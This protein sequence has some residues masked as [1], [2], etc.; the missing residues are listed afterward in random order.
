MVY[1][2]M[3]RSCIAHANYQ[4]LQRM[5]QSENLTLVSVGCTPLEGPTQSSHPVSLN[6]S[7]TNSNS[8]DSFVSYQPFFLPQPEE[9]SH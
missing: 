3:E 9:V 8:S 4:Q 2:D 5:I 6:P 1:D 7:Y